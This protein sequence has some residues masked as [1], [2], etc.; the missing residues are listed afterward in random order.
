M[1][2]E[3]DALQRENARKLAELEAELEERDDQLLEYRDQV[4]MPHEDSPDIGNDDAG[5]REASG[6]GTAVPVGRTHS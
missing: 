1:K 4:S 3:Y 2:A 6:H 5:R